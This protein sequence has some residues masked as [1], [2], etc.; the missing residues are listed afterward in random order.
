MVRVEGLDLQEELRHVREAAKV[1]VGEILMDLRQA[2][3]GLRQVKGEL[4]RVR[5]DEAKKKAE[6]EEE[7]G[8]GAAA[9]AG[10]S[11]A[12]GGKRKEA[13]NPAASASAAAAAATAAAP[14]R[15]YVVSEGSERSTST[16]TTSSSSCPSPPLPAES[17]CSAEGGEEKSGAPSPGVLKLSA[18]VEKAEARLSS[19]ERSANACVGLCKDLGEY[20]GEGADEA[21][22]HHIFRTLVQFLDLLQEAKKAE[23][24]C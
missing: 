14:T 15:L 19:I 9:E 2:R 18:F 11:V 20:F 12:G 3:K 23:G 5:D 24:L 7:D 22:A 4:Q 16:S 10:T 8:V 21:Q 17:S 6:E 1:P 13:L